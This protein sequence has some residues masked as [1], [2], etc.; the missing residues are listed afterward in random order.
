MTT[1][2]E[3]DRTIDDSVRKVCEGKRVGVAFS[4]GMDSGLLAALASKYAKSVTC[5][6]CG[7]DDAFD[8]AAGK[9]LAEKLGLPWVHCRISEENIEDTIRELILA[10]GVSDPFTISY[11]LQLFTVCREADERIILSGQG[12]DEYFG[13]CAS[14]VN[15][16]DSEYTAFTD[17]GIERMMKVSQP[18]ELAIASHFKKQLRYPYLDEE[19][20]SCIEKIDPEELRPR[21]LDERKSVLK[22]VATELGFP[23]L[24]HR[25]KKASQYGSNTTELIREMARSKG[26]RY[27]G[28]IAGIYESLGLRNANLLRDSALDVR[29]DPI[30]VHD[31]KIVLKELGLTDSEAIARFYRKMVKEGNL[32][33]LEK[34]RE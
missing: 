7:T 28:Y 30:L 34:D 18:C 13:G 5:Y 17:W 9:E 16:D 21:S 11:E 14:S 8:V 3:L 10:T 1:Y 25:T 31:S 19:V 6:T 29:M 24:A 12:S 32:D 20:L 26:L 27:N 2:A 4:G 23:I 15:E 22:T 33:F